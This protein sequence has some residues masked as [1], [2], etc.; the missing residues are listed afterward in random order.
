MKLT[1][2]WAK[3]SPQQP[4]AQAAMDGRL[5]SRTV[6]FEY[7]DSWALFTML[8][9]HQPVPNDFDRLADPDPQTLV[10][11]VN[12]S[13]TSGQVAQPAG[14]D[15]SLQAKV[16]VRIKLRPPGKPDN[17]RMRGFPTEAPSLDPVQTQAQNG[18]GGDD[19]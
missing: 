10:F 6:V 1:L 11:I 18:T 5:N 9:R 13:K 2:R 8:A 4:A 14:G 16:F 15:V 17:L 7:R 19:E 3:D 12:D